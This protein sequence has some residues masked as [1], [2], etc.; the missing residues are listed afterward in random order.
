M[1]TVDEQV[2]PDKDMEQL[3]QQAHTYLHNRQWQLAQQTFA[4]L[5]GHDEQDE[6][7]LNGLALALDQLGDYDLMY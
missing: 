5:L 2:S 3:R 7:A 6:D 4:A 1:A